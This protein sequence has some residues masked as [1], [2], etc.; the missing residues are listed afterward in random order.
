MWEARRLT[1]LWAFT[2]W[3]RDTFTL[4]LYLIFS[5]HGLCHDFLQGSLGGES[6]N[7]LTNLRLSYLILFS[8][9]A[10]GHS[11][12]ITRN[13]RIIIV[14]IVFNVESR[15]LVF[16]RTSCFFCFFFSIL[17]LSKYP[18]GRGQMPSLPP[19]P[20]VRIRTPLP[21]SLP[22]FQCLSLPVA[23]TITHCS[24]PTAATAI[25]KSF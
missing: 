6:E 10:I 11:R 8:L 15:R 7:L 9:I 3:Y 4:Y 22:L 5:F 12:N 2:A 17:I 21:S 24:Q 1:T 13:N 18:G 16:P 19:P 25:F 14:R 23:V 20:P